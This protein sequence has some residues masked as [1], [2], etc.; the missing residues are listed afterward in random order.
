MPKRSSLFENR[1][2][3]LGEGVV[4]G[5]AREV[6]IAEVV[7]RGRNRCQALRGG[8]VCGGRG[9]RTSGGRVFMYHMCDDTYTNDYIGTCVEDGVGGRVEDGRLC[10]T[11]V[12][13]HTQTIT[14]KPVWRTG[15][16]TGG[17]R[18]IMY[19]MCYDAYT[20]DYTETC[21]EDGVEDG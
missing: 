1:A 20:T 16:R 6:M 8:V 21:V 2:T 15:G 12:M 10:T 13:I 3:A 11:C 7:G 9:G 14:W 18:V 19:Y 5:G 4:R 17:G